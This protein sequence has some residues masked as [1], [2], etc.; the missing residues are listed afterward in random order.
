MTDVMERERE[1][2]VRGAAVDDGFNLEAAVD[3]NFNDI[4]DTVFNK[5]LED[6][7]SKSSDPADF[8]ITTGNLRSATALAVTALPNDVR[9]R[10]FAGPAR[11][12][13]DDSGTNVNLD[14]VVNDADDKARDA[15][16]GGVKQYIC[17]EAYAWF[18]ENLAKLKKWV[19]EKGI[20]E[21][22]KEMGAVAK[23][24]A[25][26]AAGSIA[27]AIGVSMAV[28]YL[29]IGVAVAAVG[30]AIYVLVK[31]GLPNYCKA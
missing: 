31:K 27:G 10:G 21:A 25:I 13:A 16:A 24:L 20:G 23:K 19:E 17:K 1:D 2:N 18:N 28:A 15:A 12:F 22:L 4:V 8:R 9:V 7:L 14:S 29:F 5:Q 26:A 30:A 11:N 6:Q 3:A